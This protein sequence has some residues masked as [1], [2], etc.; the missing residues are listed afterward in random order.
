MI[1]KGRKWEV[2]TDFTDWIMQ[3]IG[4]DIEIEPIQDKQV[5]KV[6]V[7]EWLT[8]AERRSRANAIDKIKRL[9][10]EAGYKNA[11]IK[12]REKR[13]R[14]VKDEEREEIEKETGKEKEGCEKKSEEE[15]KKTRIMLSKSLTIIMS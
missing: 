8:I 13:W 2:D 15:R 7:E 1:R 12:I 11:R 3:V 4:E 10:E 9:T 6:T 5:F 14:Y